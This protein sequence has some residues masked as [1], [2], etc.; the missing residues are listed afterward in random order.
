MSLPSRIASGLLALLAF[1]CE[2]SSPPAQ[3]PNAGPTLTV[4]PQAAPAAPAAAPADPGPPPEPPWASAGGLSYREVALGGADLEAPLPMIVAIHGLGDG[5]DN[6]RHLYDGF[7]EPARLILPRGLDSTPDGGW[8]WFPIRARD[9]D[10]DAL[11]TGI[12]GAAD[13]IAEGIRALE[14]S[15]PT[16][17]KP[18]VTGFS[19][20]G[21]LTFALAVQHP[22]VV[23]HAIAVGGWLPPPLVPSPPST[24]GSTTATNVDYP[25][26]VALHGT[27]DAAVLFEPTQLA[28]QALV[29]RGIDAEIVQY[30][31]V[32][33]MIPELMRRDLYDRLSDAVLEERRRPAP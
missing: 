2:A 31:G 20:G 7:T 12:A 6:F 33:H 3:P 9:P 17:G 22:D 14:Q 18:I 27:A 10:V 19:Q 29:D 28:V 23:G 5:P 8:S 30:E 15:R 1:G 4:A 11:S 21:M 26:L 25:P 16:L 13:R 24:K 32:G